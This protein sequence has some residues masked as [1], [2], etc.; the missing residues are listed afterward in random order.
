M[1]DFLV[2]SRLALVWSLTCLLGLGAS[3]AA[4]AAASTRSP[5]APHYRQ[6]SQGEMREMQRQLPAGAVVPRMPL[7]YR[8]KANGE[9]APDPRRSGDAVLFGDVDGDGRP[10]YV[11]GCLFRTEKLAVPPPAPYPDGRGAMM[12]NHLPRDDRAH[13]VVFKR[14]PNGHWMRSW[15]S[16][17]LGF[18]FGVPEDNLREVQQGI[19]SLDELRAPIS[20]ADIDGDGVLEIVYYAWSEDTEHLGALP[21]IYRWDGARWG[22]IAPQGDRF[23]VLD[24]DHDGRLEVIIGSRYIGYST[25]NDDVPR[26]YRWDGRRYV[27]ASADFPSYFAELA[28]RYR[29]AVRSF[30]SH[31]Q[32]YEKDLWDRAIQQAEKRA[33]P[34]PSE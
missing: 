33:K 31:G 6:P 2:I 5:A 29:G 10:E 13:L 16:P 21:G 14:G 4:R 28:R 32:K 8:W 11:L 20:L 15:T 23:S 9:V 25:G 3:G 22:N 30:E 7:A 18:R 27:E 34:S 1:R 17:G 24:L 12:K 19:E 26:V